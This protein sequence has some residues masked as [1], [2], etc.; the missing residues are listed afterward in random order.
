MSCCENFDQA[1]KDGLIVF[2]EP[3]EIIDGPLMNQVISEYFMRKPRPS[4]YQY[5]G[6]NYCPFC[7]KPRSLK[8][9]G[10]LA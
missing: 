1:F 3:R 8:T 7:G 10:F 4:G 6:I 2:S 5:Y 9:Q